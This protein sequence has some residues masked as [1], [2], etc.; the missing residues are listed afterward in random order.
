MAKKSFEVKFYRVFLGTGVVS[1]IKSVGYLNCLD[2][3]ANWVS[4]L[5]VYFVPDG[6]ALPPGWFNPA[7]NAGAMF[8]PISQMELFLDLLRNEMPVFAS[9][10]DQNPLEGNALR[11]HPEATGEGE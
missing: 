9:M 3:S 6:S 5:T 4:Q 11:T 1:N 8:R 2:A 10:D 7:T